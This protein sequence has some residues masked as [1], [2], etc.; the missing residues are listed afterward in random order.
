MCVW[1]GGAGDSERERER[2]RKREREREVGKMRWL[3]VG[4]A[5]RTI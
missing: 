1:G 2:K 5:L 4:M 3:G